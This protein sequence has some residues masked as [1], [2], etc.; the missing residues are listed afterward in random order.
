M[1]TQLLAFIFSLS[2]EYAH[3]STSNPTCSVATRPGVL[4]SNACPTDNFF[5]YIAKVL[6]QNNGYI[7]AVAVIIVVFSGLQYMLAMGNS[8]SQGKA[9]ERIIG[10]VIGIVFLTLIRFILT[11]LADNLS[12][13]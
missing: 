4:V 9:K 3:A 6:N 8:S 5:Q 11:I 13:G 12:V 10:V 2:P 1:I 7:I